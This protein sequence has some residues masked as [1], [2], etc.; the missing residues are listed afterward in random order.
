MNNSTLVDLI[1]IQEGS[2]RA[3]ATASCSRRTPPE[4]FLV[5][6]LGLDIC[7]SNPALVHRLVP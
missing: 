7:A 1:C 6:Q 3:I 2:R 4:E 5:H